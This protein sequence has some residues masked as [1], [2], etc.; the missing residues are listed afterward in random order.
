MESAESPGL[1]VEVKAS[2]DALEIA[3]DGRL[4]AQSLPAAWTAVVDAVRKGSKKIIIRGEKLSYCDGAG[5][6]LFAELRRLAAERGTPA[7]EFQ[8][9]N[10][11]LRRLVD[12]SLLK[13]SKAG[14]LHPPKPPGF[15]TFVGIMA[16][17]VIADQRELIGFV[18][19]LTLALIWALTHPRR[20]RLRDLLG[21]AERVGANA[22][23]VVSLLGLL[24]GVILAFQMARPLKDLGA[25]ATIPIIVGFSLIRELAP[26]ITAV[27]VAG[28][29][30]SAFAAEIGTMKVTEELAA[31][32]TFGLAPTQFLVVPRVLAAVI[33]TPLLTVYN[34]VLGLLGGCIVMMSM[35]Y[36]FHFYVS[37]I[38]DAIKV[39]DFLG[40]VFKSVV[41]AL[42]IAGVG[43]LRGVQTKE[44][45]GAVGESATRAVVAG[46]VLTIIADS[47]LGVV[48]YHLNI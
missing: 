14:G 10:A 33:V 36:S 27:I 32:K 48:F 30:G 17:R 20:L 7:P 21:V 45:P 12:L 47:V 3:L 37:Q 23:P 19:E 26:L 42:I 11:E 29:S 28:R 34:M 35:G 46:I 6:G 44:G 24:V 4:D 38:T 15:V 2:S 41:F 16:A 39:H 13:D 40:G 9:F 8:G 25:E 5:L 31:L 43:C 18:G 22:L 1:K